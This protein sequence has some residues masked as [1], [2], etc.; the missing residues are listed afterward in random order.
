MHISRYY[1]IIAIT[2]I[3]L[4]KLIIMYQ[5]IKNKS[6][7]FNNLESFMRFVHY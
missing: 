3:L 2:P 7:H 6:K 5:A 1:I 4:N